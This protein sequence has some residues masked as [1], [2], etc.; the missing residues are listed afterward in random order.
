VAAQHF[1]HPFRP[2]ESRMRPEYARVRVLLEQALDRIHVRMGM[3]EDLVLIR[4][5]GRTRA[6]NRSIGI[7]TVDVE[8]LLSPHCGNAPGA[9]R[10]KAATVSCGTSSR[11]HLGVR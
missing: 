4:E 7:R 9:L 8:T 3:Q 1:A 10:Y 6:R 2:L 5:L 11:C